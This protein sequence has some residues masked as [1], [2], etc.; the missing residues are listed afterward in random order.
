MGCKGSQKEPEPAAVKQQTAPKPEQ[1]Q[2]AEKPASTDEARQ[3]KTFTECIQQRSSKEGR[4]CD[5]YADEVEDRL[6]KREA[7]SLA[8]LPTIQRAATMAGAT[9]ACERYLSK[10]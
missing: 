5:C 9:K 6:G 4:F 3:R 1:P 8:D 10:K 2:P 7:K